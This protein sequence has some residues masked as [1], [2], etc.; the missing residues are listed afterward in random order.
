MARRPPPIFGRGPSPVAVLNQRPPDDA[1]IDSNLLTAPNG[2]T[3]RPSSY[4]PDIVLVCFVDGHAQSLS[5]NVDVRVYTRSLSPA[6]S[7]YGQP[8]DGDVK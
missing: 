2:W 4:H 6:G 5:R 3:A 8:V 7:L 1:N